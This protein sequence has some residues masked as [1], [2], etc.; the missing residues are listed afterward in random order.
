MDVICVSTRP[1][2]K[3]APGICYVGAVRGDHEGKTSEVPWYKTK[4]HKLEL[5]FYVYEMLC[6]VSELQDTNCELEL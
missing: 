1:S 2:S 5:L 3:L 4:L 6:C